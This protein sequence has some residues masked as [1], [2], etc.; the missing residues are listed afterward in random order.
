MKRGLLSLL[1]SAWCVCAQADAALQESLSAV[2][3]NARDRG[4]IPAIAAMVQINGKVEAQAVVGVRAL[5]HRERATLQD[6]WHLGSDIKAMTA[7]LIARLAEKGT[8]KLD[9]TLAEL[10]PAM[11]PAMDPAFRTVTMTQLLSHTAGVAPLVDPKELPPVLA[12]IAPYQEVKA[13][14]AAIA[15]HFLSR[16]P[17]SKPGAF[18]YSNVGYVIAG[19]VAEAR[20]GRSFEELI[21]AEVWA[22]L[23]ISHAGFGAP[24]RSG[25]FDE[26]LGHEVGLFGLKAVDPGSRRSDNLPVFAPAGTAHMTLPDWMLFAQDQL[27]GAHGHG[28]LLESATYRKL[29]VPVTPGYALGWRVAVAPDGTPAVLTHGGSNGMW[30]AAIH[31]T[32]ANYRIVLVAMNAAGKPA[33][34]AADTIIT[35]LTGVNARARPRGK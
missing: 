15:S 17:T 12:V 19:A 14:R 26:P 23:G 9:D 11:A 29:H 33:N 22:P 27:D 28:K 3:A 5:R 4:K 20:T 25:K 10:L 30:K 24:G 16:P 34:D 7:T 32:P 8:L 1:L 6:R 35:E 21:R 18:V 2:I 13:Q 31:I